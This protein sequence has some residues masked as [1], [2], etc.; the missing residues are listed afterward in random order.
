[1]RNKK[2]VLI[3]T[4]RYDQKHDELLRSLLARGYQLFCVAG[5]D[6]E[7]WEDAMDWIA[8]GD[9]SAPRYIT[10]TSHPGETEDEVIEFA[11]MFSISGASGVD[12]V[13]T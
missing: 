12:V 5:I 11:T 8:I 2:L 6:C 10:T 1:M 9:G 4:T 3:S 7:A 13:R